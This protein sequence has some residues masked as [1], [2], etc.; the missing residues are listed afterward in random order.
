MQEY[1]KFSIYEKIS[2]FIISKYSTLSGAKKFIKINDNELE[3]TIL[4]EILI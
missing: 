3:E 4:P 2:F 1:V